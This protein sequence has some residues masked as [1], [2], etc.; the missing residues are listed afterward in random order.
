MRSIVIPVEVPALQVVH[1]IELNLLCD[2]DSRSLEAPYAPPMVTVGEGLPAELVIRHSREWD[3]ADSASSEPMEFSYEVQNDPETWLV[4][5]RKKAH[6]KAVDG[7]VEKFPLL[8]VPAKPGHLVLPNVEIKQ[9]TDVFVGM[10]T[11]YKGNAA[12]IL[13]LPDIRST[14]VRIDSMYGGEQIAGKA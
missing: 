1:T 9:V 5:G 4:S 8:L 2:S 13:V 6:F 12:T 11:D 7:G 14:T 10:E 3:T